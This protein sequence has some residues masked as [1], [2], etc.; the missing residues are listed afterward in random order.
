MRRH[1]SLCGTRNGDGKGIFE[2]LVHAEHVASFNVLHFK[3]TFYRRKKGKWNCNGLDSLLPF[4][5]CFKHNKNIFFFGLRQA[6]FM[7]IT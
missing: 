4:R 6:T 5:K 1:R 3:D 2:T 7:K